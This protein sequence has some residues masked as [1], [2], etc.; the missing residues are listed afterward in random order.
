MRLRIHGDNV[1]D[2]VRG[3][4]G[5]LSFVI[6]SWRVNDAKTHLNETEF[7]DLCREVIEHRRKRYRAALKRR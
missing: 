2:H 3:E 7:A 6:C 1:L 4:D 5:S